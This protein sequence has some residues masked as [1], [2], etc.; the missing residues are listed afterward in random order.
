MGINYQRWYRPKIALSMHGRT[1]KQCRERYTNHLDPTMKNTPW[2]MEE[3]K[4]IRDLFP[5]FGTKWSQYMAFLP[6]RSDNSIKNRYHTISRKNSDGFTNNHLTLT[7]KHALPGDSDSGT[8]REDFSFDENKKHLG[9]L[10]AAR[11]EIDR[12]IRELKDQC[13]SAT[14]TLCNKDEGECSVSLEEQQNDP[15][16]TFDFDWNES[17]TSE[18]SV[19]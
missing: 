8:S 13:S 12:E 14:T 10:M 9:K 17:V 2:S 5:K 15:E 7:Y 1:G 3:S 19:G 11:D 6:G 4:I 18:L 16:F